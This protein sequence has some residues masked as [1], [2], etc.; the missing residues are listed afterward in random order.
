[1]DSSL[2]LPTSLPLLLA[3]TASAL[4]LQR[5]VVGL[6]DP[7]GGASHNSA[8]ATVTPPY[9]A[10]AISTATGTAASHLSAAA[11]VSTK[12]RASMPGDAVHLAAA[13][14]QA[15]GGTSHRTKTATARPPHV[16]AAAAAFKPTAT[17]AK[18]RPAASTRKMQALFLKDLKFGACG[19]P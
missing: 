14:L 3:V 5:A 18:L 13:L 8:V 17:A 9:A 10:A 11:A 16:A 6:L 19:E 15:Q 7:H 1:M 12:H 4:W 2:P